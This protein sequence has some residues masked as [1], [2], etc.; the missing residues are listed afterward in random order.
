LILCSNFIF[1]STRSITL[2][3]PDTYPVAHYFLVGCQLIDQAIS[4]EI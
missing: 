1:H 3:I 2:I 4:L